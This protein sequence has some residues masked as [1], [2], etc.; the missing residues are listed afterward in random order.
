MTG[1]IRSKASMCSQHDGQRSFPNS[2]MLNIK[3]RSQHR[4]RIPSSPSPLLCIAIQRFFLAGVS[5]IYRDVIPGIGEVGNN[6]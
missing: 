3:H 2:P 4:L 6:H 5:I 1:G